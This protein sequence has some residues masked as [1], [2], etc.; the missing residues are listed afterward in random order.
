[1]LLI[2]GLFLESVYCQA[3]P[4]KDVFLP[5]STILTPIHAKIKCTDYKKIK[6]SVEMQAE[7]MPFVFY[8]PKTPGKTP[9]FVVFDRKTNVFSVC[10]EGR[11]IHGKFGQKVNS[12]D[13][14]DI[15]NATMKDLNNNGRTDLLVGHLQC[16]EGPCL[17]FWYLM[18]VGPNNL[19]SD[20]R[21]S[22]TSIDV[23]S[24]KNQSFLKIND[25]CFTYEFGTAFDWFY[26]AEFKKNG[27]L[28][29]INP[30]EIGQRFPNQVKD[31]TNE[32]T[33]KALESKNEPGSSLNRAYAEISRLIGRAYE[34]DD[35]KKLLKELDIITK[36][37]AKSG[38]LPIHCDIKS[39]IENLA[40]KTAESLR[41]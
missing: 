24:S 37:F 13:L 16:A 33:L 35:S 23:I 26:I 18:E 11:I 3:S 4:L 28:S 38:G 30:G 6:K 10:E 40:A 12:D 31:Y 21:I 29:L 27:Q 2:S 8:E 9:S 22:A 32:A 20:W 39:V 17:G 41:K 14:V 36:S 25:T 19:R 5:M 1:M 7:D 15:S 34:G